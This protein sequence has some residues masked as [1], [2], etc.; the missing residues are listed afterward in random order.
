MGTGSWKLIATNESTV[1]A[2]SLLDPIV[3]EDG[4]GD[5]RFPDTPRTNESDWFQVFG[6]SDDLLN[7]LVTS[8]A[9]PRGGGR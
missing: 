7:Q 5:G 4:E 9:A 8:E 3:V 2:K 6:E 1:L